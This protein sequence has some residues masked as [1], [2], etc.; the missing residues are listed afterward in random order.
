MNLST[1]IVIPCYKSSKTLPVLVE[2]L[3]TTLKSYTTKFEIILVNDC[4]PDDTWQTIT[5]LCKEYEV[6]K[7][8]NLSRNRG[9]QIAILA[10]LAQVKHDI[11]VTIDD[12]LEHRPE[13]IPAMIEMLENKDL[14]L[15]IAALKNKTHGIIR[16]LGTFVVRYLSKRILGIKKEIKFSSFRVMKGW[17]ARRA[18]EIYMPQP[19]VGYLLL[20][21]TNRVENYTV[22]HQSRVHSERSGHNFLFLFKYFL[23]ML[24][25]HSIIPLQI[26]SLLGFIGFGGALILSVIYFT[27]GL[28]GYFGIS[29]FTSIM[30]L[31][32]LLGSVLLGSVG[33]LGQYII[34][35]IQI[36]ARNPL[37]YI[38]EQQED[39]TTLKLKEFR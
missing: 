22:E 10:G 6:V 26:I 37:Y 2:R 18:A 8:V 12:D 39:P 15:V 14:D 20:Q 24:F 7:G 32:S 28:F 17:V 31:L 23:T 16:A 30:V 27:L 13:D 34:Q 38:R 19:V 3:I 35:L 25:V 5:N 36:S 21:V 29:G 1:S 9:Q 4:S 11:V 33:V